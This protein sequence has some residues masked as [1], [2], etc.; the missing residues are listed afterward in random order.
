MMAFCLPFTKEI[1]LLHCYDCTKI[2]IEFV[3]FVGMA[4]YKD[5]FCKWG[6]KAKGIIGEV[7]DTRKSIFNTPSSEHIVDGL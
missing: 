6:A 3:D 2:E 4:E 1:L 7:S 5:V